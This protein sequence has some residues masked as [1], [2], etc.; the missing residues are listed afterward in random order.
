MYIGSNQTHSPAFGFMK[1]NVQ[2]SANVSL[3][4]FVC[5][6]VDSLQISQEVSNIKHLCETAWYK[7]YADDSW[8]LLNIINL[9]DTIKRLQCA[10][11]WY[12]LCLIWCSLLWILCLTREKG[13]AF[14][15]TL[16]HIQ[17]NSLLFPKPGP[18]EMIRLLLVFLR[19]EWYH[20]KYS[21]R[22]RTQREKILP[23]CLYPSL[24]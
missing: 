17:S 14:I 21:K 19:T 18:K 10:K 1:G 3:F 12:H 22:A 8:F 9:I 7:N 2:G 11:S 6:N 20:V 24:F 5:F 23:L 15:S 16:E 13:K 4:C